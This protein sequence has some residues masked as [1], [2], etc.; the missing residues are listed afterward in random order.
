[1][2]HPELSIR[3]EPATAADLPGIL[4]VW[5]AAD[6]H[7]TPTDD[8]EG[9]SRLLERQ[10]D[11]LLLAWLDQE[12]GGEIAGTLIAAFDGW[13]GNLYRLA[14]APGHRRR[15]IGRALV[16]EAARR[17]REQGVR[18]ISAFVVDA[19]ADALAFWDSL[20]DTGL[21]RDPLPKRRY[22]WNL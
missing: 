1:M 21:I 10:P 5:R 11:G 4:A 12:E 7:P 3:I 16:L 14:V 8:A 22:I 17:L 2:G 19:D 6:A 13:R 20:A 18:R 9:V 15:G